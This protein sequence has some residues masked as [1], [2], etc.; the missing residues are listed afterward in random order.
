MNTKDTVLIY[1]LTSS[2]DPLNIR[3]VGK[4]SQKLSL[5]LSGHRTL[6]RTGNDHR[7]NWIR[8]EVGFGNK[9]NIVQLD[10]V[11]SDDWEFWEI[12]WIAELKRIGYNLVNGTPGGNQSDNSIPI[13]ALD[14]NGVFVRRFSS[15]GS[16]VRFYELTTRM[17]NGSINSKSKYKNMKF[18]RESEYS[19][20]IDYSKGDTDN[21]IDDNILGDGEFYRLIKSIVRMKG[22][23]SSEKIILSVII[24]STEE[25]I[26]FNMSN[27]KLADEI[28]MEYSSIV[29][30]ISSLKKKKF[31]KTYKVTNG[32]N[33]LVIG[34]VAIPQGDFFPINLGKRWKNGTYAE[35]N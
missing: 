34:R 12:F 2:G 7:G 25:G 33:K 11:W 9:I 5:R 1:G 27:E 32:I 13:I 20:D 28:G 8:K 15:I 19:A 21:I 17:L 35:Y 18:I 31:I 26:E 23:T 22:L 10:E 16:A 29:R 3:Y 30:T 4:T 24:S 14:S 6:S